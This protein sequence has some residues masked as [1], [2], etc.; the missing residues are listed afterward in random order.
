MSGPRS[1]RTFAAA[2]AVVLAANGV[3]EAGAKPVRPP[4]GQPVDESHEIPL[5]ARVG[6]PCVAVRTPAA[7]ILLARGPLEAAAASAP[8]NWRTEPERE[9]LIRGGRAK[10]LL[11]LARGSPDATGCVRVDA[12]RLGDAAHLVVEEL[13]AGD[14]AVIGHGAGAPDAAITVRY[15]GVRASPTS[16][17]GEIRFLRGDPRTMFF[18]VEWWA[19]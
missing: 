18:G 7:S 17:R 12:A 19:S 15:V 1:A 6:A 9:A 3:P 5:R 11:A 2:L 8:S 16:G 13:E 14:A 10:A 4:A